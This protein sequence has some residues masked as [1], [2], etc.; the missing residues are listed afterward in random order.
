[1]ASEKEIFSN[2]KDTELYLELFLNSPKKVQQLL[3][4]S[5]VNN[6]LYP[7]F[8]N[9]ENIKSPIEQIFITAFELY[10]RLENKKSIFLFPQKEISCNGKKYYID[11]EFEADDYLTYLT[12]GEEIKNNKF[13]LAIECDGYEFHQ[14]SKEQVQ[15]DNEREYDLKISGYDILR[16]SGTQIYNAPLKCAKDIYDYIIQKIKEE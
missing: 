14:K 13:K 1:M 11:F 15:R 2:Y 3:M 16:F 4:L 5:L 10:C 9:D 7:E 6:H 8:W 12:F